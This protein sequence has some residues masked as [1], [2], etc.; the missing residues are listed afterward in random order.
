MNSLYLNEDFRHSVKFGNVRMAKILIE[1]GKVDIM[2]IEPIKACIKYT[3]LE[4]VKH[5]IELG[6]DFDNNKDKLLEIA[7]GSGNLEMVTFFVTKG[8][9]INK[10]TMYDGRYHNIRKSIFKCIEIGNL[11]ILQYLVDN[12]ALIHDCY[13]I[14]KFAIYCG[15]L[16][17]IKYFVNQKVNLTEGL[18]RCAVDRG[19][20]TIMKYLIEECNYTVN[21]VHVL[22]ILAEYGCLDMIEY[23][24]SKGANLH[25]FDILITSISNNRTAIV[26]YMVSF[27]PNEINNLNGELISDIVKAISKKELSDYHSLIDLFRN[28]GIDVYDMI[29][30]EC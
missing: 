29:E 10:I 8:A 19:E 13:G 7:I 9:D 4:L 5:I 3:N 28:I 16:E 21:E 17:M 20:F 27:Y 24:L 30:K 18:L 6:F 25:C 1:L 2:K 12:G 11:E 14:F 23:L 26:N 22:S 15:N